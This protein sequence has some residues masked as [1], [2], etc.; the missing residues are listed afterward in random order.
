VTVLASV[1]AILAKIPLVFIAAGKRACVEQSQI[2]NVEGHWRSRSISGWKTS[3]MC[4][5]Y[6]VK[7]RSAMAEGPVHL[8]LDCYSANCTET[9]KQV[10]AKLGITLHFIPPSLTDEFQPLDRAV[11]GV[12]NAQAKTPLSRKMSS[13]SSGTED[14]ITR[15]GRYDHSMVPAGTICH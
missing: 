13:E 12:L 2:G 11:F 3:D 1:T 4:Q 10:A 8:L 14:K 6:L 15:C 9:M 5:D 7:L